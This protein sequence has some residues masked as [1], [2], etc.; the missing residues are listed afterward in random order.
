[1]Y[2]CMYM[3]VYVCVYQKLPGHDAPN[4]IGMCVHVCVY[5]YAYVHARVHIHTSTHKCTYELNTK[6]RVSCFV[7]PKLN[8]MIFFFSKTYQ[9]LGFLKQHF[10]VYM[11]IYVYILARCSQMYVCIHVWLGFL[12]IKF[13]HTVFF[14]LFRFFVKRD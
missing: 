11:H 2:V 4:C 6:H 14:S 9:L 12:K 1:M 13:A 10:H 8:R 3:H 5:V 7:L